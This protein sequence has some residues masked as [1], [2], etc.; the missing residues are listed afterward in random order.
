[1]KRVTFLLLAGI[2][3]AC[4]VGCAGNESAIPV[5]QQDTA[6]VAQPS[7]NEPAGEGASTEVVQV[8][9]SVPNMT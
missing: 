8:S 5:A 1:M 6:E 4:W 2:A 3:A 9:L 7:V